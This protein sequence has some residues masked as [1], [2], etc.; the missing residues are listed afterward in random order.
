MDSE[1][2]RI[3]AEVSGQDWSAIEPAILGTLF[4]RGLDPGKRSQLGAHFTAKED[5]L[6]IVEPV[7]MAPLRRRWETVQTEARGLAAKRDAGRGF[8]GNRSQQRGGVDDG[9]SGHLADFPE[10]RINKPPNSSQRQSFAKDY[11]DASPHLGGNHLRGR[12]GQCKAMRP[13]KAFTAT[14]DHDYLTTAGERSWR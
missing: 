4:E 10:D 8:A 9:W 14:A 6:L 13:A 3:L 7:L 5:I 1:S 12:S 2:V 11:A